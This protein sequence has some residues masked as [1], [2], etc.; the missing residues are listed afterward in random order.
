MLAG[1]T[2]DVEH[3]A[4]QLP[5]RGQLVE[6]WLGSPDVPGRWRA[7]GV[8]G[9]EVVGVGDLWEEVRQGQSWRN[10]RHRRSCGDIPDFAVPF[11][12]RRK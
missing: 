7:D 1:A 6:S 8:D 10:V 2:T 9:I 5:G 12:D 4:D 11:A 3:P